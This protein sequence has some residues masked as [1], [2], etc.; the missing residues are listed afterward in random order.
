MSNENPTAALSPPVDA[1]RPLA[2]F[3]NGSDIWIAHSP[4]DAKAMYIANTGEDDPECHDWQP[5]AP[6][7]EIGFKPDG[8]NGDESAGV[9]TIAEWIAS[10]GR[11]FLAS[12]DL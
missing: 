9:Q 4:A 1:D 11:G 7:M 6:T 2:A 5:V 10:D 3:Y 12:E 8:S